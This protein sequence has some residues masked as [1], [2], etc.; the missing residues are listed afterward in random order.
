MQD[1]TH[2]FKAY[3][4]RGKVGSELTPELVHKIGQAFADWLPTE[5][6][7]VVGHDMRPDSKALSQELIQGLSLQGREVWDIG[8]ATSDMVYFSPAKYNLAGG[9]MITAS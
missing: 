8:L 6:P 4:I 5:G 7:V 3:D 9:A 1:L 2:I